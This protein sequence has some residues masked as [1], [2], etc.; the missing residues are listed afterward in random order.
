M[1]AML[2]RLLDRARQAIARLAPSWGKTTRENEAD[3][4]GEKLHDL[5]WQDED[6]ESVRRQVAGAEAKGN[7]LAETVFRARPQNPFSKDC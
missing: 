4:V 1:L 6:E 3:S 5:G 7:A 2:Q